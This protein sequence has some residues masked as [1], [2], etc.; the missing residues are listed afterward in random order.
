MSPINFVIAI[1]T[2]NSLEKLKIAINSVLRQSTPSHIKVMIAISNIASGDGTYEYLETLKDK[3]NFFIHNGPFE[4]T[5]SQSM[6]FYCLGEVIPKTADWV[7]L[8]GDDDK[9][10][11]NSILEVCR[12]L[13]KNNESELELLVACSS[14][15]TT[16]SKKIVKKEIF[17]LCD[18]FGY[19][20]MLGWISSLILRPESMIKILQDTYLYRGIFT[21]DD[22]SIRLNT[23]YP[24]SAFPHSFS[25]LRYL[26]N[27]KGIFIDMP[28]VDTQ[29]N[30]QC[31]I[32]L[33]QWSEDNV[34]TRYM[35]VIDDLE[36]LLNCG[37]IKNKSCS[38]NFFRYQIYYFWDHWGQFLL[39]DLNDKCKSNESY[40]PGF[41]EGLST[42]N[43]ANWQRMT[44]L[45]PFFKNSFD[46][47]YMLTF[48][49][50]GINYSQLFIRSGLNE[51]LGE[52]Y[53]LSYRE[54]MRIPTYDFEINTLNS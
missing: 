32:T 28:L 36:K 7:W 38:K 17:G 50:S 10:E 45:L 35:L 51:A 37:V 8:L 21:I 4:N 34:M 9:L 29:D 1:P 16:N 3:K 6:N 19:H 48:I 41:I 47:K 12:V 26:A 5:D 52:D 11:N 54:I 46:R 53:L 22:P 15:R 20:E 23:K 25:I 44:K 27:K 42:S 49:Q 2:F 39:T 31:Q 40:K 24:Y 30:H 13:E 14:K 18:E 33:N 43:T